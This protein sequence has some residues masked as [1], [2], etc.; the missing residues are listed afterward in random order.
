VVLRTVSRSLALR[1]GAPVRMKLG[2]QT[3]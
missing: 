3:D 2:M 1:K